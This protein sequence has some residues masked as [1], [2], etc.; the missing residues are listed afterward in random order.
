MQM[1]RAIFVTDLRVLNFNRNS[2]NDFENENMQ[3]DE[4]IGITS[5]S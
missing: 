3:T 2:L 5:Q 1:H 4:Q